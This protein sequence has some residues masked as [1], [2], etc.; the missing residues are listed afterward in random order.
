MVVLTRVVWEP[1]VLVNY[2]LSVYKEL[3]GKVE[4]AVILVHLFKQINL[5]S[6]LFPVVKKSV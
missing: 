4:V 1:Q 5:I 6:N 3:T 2:T